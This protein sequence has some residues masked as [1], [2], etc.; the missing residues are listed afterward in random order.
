MARD[1]WVENPSWSENTEMMRLK[2]VEMQLELRPLFS[3]ILL[4]PQ[5]KIDGL[6]VEIEKNI[7]GRT[8]RTTD[9]ATSKVFRGVR[10]YFDVE[11]SR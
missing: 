7:D 3:G 9:A 4:V 2:R 11:W 6:R 5:L 8:D 1:I 10:F